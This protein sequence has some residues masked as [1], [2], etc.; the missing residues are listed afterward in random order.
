MYIYLFF[1]YSFLKE[2]RS[3]KEMLFICNVPV[4]NRNEGNARY[5]VYLPSHLQ[6]LV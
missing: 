1:I 2:L 6:V 3:G 5:V 4:A